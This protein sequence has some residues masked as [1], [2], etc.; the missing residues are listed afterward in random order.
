MNDP[1]KPLK[2]A[3]VV[4]TQKLNEF[5]SARA[6]IDKQRAAIDAEI[7]HWKQ[8]VDCLRTVSEDEDEDPSDVE[9]SA[10]VGGRPGKRMIKF[11]D[12]V[13]L[14]LQQNRNVAVT[15]PDIRDGLTNLGFQFSK[16]RQ[17]LTPIHN[18]LKRLEEQ[19][20]VRPE[21]TNDGQIVGYRSISSIERALAE[22]PP[23][24]AEATGEYLNEAKRIAKMH[25][26]I[27]QRDIE[28]I[29]ATRQA[30]EQVAATMQRDVE[31]I[32]Q[33]YTKKPKK[34]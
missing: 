26:A 7:I 15:P 9:V 34:G 20:E 12:A 32:K 29:E 25:Q 8:L 3:L 2:E 1:L 19:G 16:Y 13:R 30:A 23:S 33:Q 10:F 11:T 21:K 18:C 24:Y 5:V 28:T 4:A 17:P 22:E 31:A 27:V 6:E 14:V